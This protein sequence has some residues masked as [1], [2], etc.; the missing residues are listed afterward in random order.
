[1][2]DIISIAAALNSLKAATDIA[3]LLRESDLSLERA[4]LKLKLADLISALAD[5]KLELIE[6]Q[7]AL[8]EK[9]KRISELE[10]AFESKES[11]VRRL[12]AYYLVDEAGNPIGIP[13]CL[14]CWENDHKKRQLV[15]EVKDRW[16]RVCTACGHRYDGR[17]AAHIQPPTDQPVEQD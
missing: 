17:L 10:E 12:D 4:E 8:S 5:T 1:M 3:K 15:Q 16:V 13:Y 14:R 2:P 11:L 7:E 9:D 6:V